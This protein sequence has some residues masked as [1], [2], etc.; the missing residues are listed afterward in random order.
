MSDRPKTLTSILKKCSICRNSFN[1]IRH[2]GKLGFVGGKRVAF[3]ADC[4]SGL[5]DFVEQYSERK[6]DE[7]LV[8]R[9]KDPDCPFCRKI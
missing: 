7:V 9:H 8:Q 6:A 2:G 3:C 5:Y 4:V 1:P